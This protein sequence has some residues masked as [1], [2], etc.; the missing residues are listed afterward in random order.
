MYNKLYEFIEFYFTQGTPPHRISA[1]LVKAG[2]PEAMVNE[3]LNAWL[4]AHGH[5]D[6]NT[7]FED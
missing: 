6:K 2:W 7:P 1:E 5:K 3:V 4:E